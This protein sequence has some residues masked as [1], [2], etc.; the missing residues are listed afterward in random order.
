MFA[1]ESRGT[2]TPVLMARSIATRPWSTFSDFTI[3]ADSPATVTG[4]PGFIPAASL[5]YAVTW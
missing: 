1:V 3:P 4:S 2:S 5:K